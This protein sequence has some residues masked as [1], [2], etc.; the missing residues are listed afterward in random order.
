MFQKVGSTDDDSVDRLFFQLKDQ[1]IFLSNKF[2]YSMT[3]PAVKL[4][5]I[6]FY[7]RI[8]PTHKFRMVSNGIMSAVIA[9]GIAVFLAAALQCRPLRALWDTNVRG[10]CFDTL[11]Y[12]LAI[13]AVN[14]V[15]DFAILVLPMPQVWTLQRPWQDKLA[16]SIIFLMGGL[17]VN[18]PINSGYDS[19]RLI[20]P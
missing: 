6:L 4:S 17:W 19:Y 12:I 9:W 5:I 1:Q 15:L 16:L 18:S 8:F 2:K 13:Q 14:I 3:S 20:I 7:R 10:Q 11:K